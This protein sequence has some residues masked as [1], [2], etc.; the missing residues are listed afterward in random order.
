ML[1]GV[2]VGEGEGAGVG[3]SLL[4]DGGVSWDL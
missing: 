1:G 4:V 2:R 3:Y